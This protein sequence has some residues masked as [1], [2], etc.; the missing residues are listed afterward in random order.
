MRRSSTARRQRIASHKVSISPRSRSAAASSQTAR[1]DAMLDTRVASRRVASLRAAPAAAAAARAGEG[2]HSC[3][4]YAASPDPHA[5][6]PG[7]DRKWV[8]LTVSLR[9]PVGQ[10]LR[11]HGAERSPRGMWRPEQAGHPRPAQR[12]NGR[13]CH[14]WPQSLH[15]HHTPRLD[16]GPTRNGSSCRF[17]RHAARNQSSPGAQT[18]RDPEEIVVPSAIPYRVYAA[19]VPTTRRCTEGCC[20]VKDE[21]RGWGMG[22]CGRAR[23]AGRASVL[24]GDVARGGA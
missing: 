8:K 12:W 6:R 17:A 2:C 19:V 10:E 24:G 1:R 11:P 18:S 20:P 23:R 9:M 5:P 14:S 13:A 21:E 3:P 7:R 22:R 16:P 4:Q 15:R